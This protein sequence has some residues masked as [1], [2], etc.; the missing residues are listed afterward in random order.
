[1]ML[2]VQQN[3][4]DQENK[5]F[6]LQYYQFSQFYIHVFIRISLS[7][8]LLRA[9]T[10]IFQII[11]QNLPE[12]TSQLT[13]QAANVM[14]FFKSEHRFPI[15]ENRVTVQDRVQAMRVAVV[16]QVENRNHRVQSKL[17]FNEI[18]NKNSIFPRKK[19]I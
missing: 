7:K 13:S 19:M 16:V 14:I 1:M 5:V 10:K 12:E 4:Q 18:L 8:M 3:S 17:Q 9:S 11:F 6:I 15:Q 2:L